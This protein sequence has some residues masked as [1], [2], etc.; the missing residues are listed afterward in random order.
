MPGQGMGGMPGMSQPQ[1][2]QAPPAPVA[3][4]GVQPSVV[5]PAQEKVTLLGVF[6]ILRPSWLFWLTNLLFF[7]PW[8]ICLGWHHGHSLGDSPEISCWLHGTVPSQWQSQ[9]KKFDLIWKI[10]G[11]WNQDWSAGC[12]ASQ[13]PSLGNRPRSAN[14]CWGLES[15][16]YWQR[17]SVLCLR[18]Q[19]S[20]KLDPNFLQASW[21]LRSFALQCTS[22]S[23]FKRESLSPLSCLSGSPLTFSVQCIVIT[24]P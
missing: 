7:N 4:A 10:T 21:I 8:N 12:C 2:S 3:V 18:I 1:Q 9:V 24:G 23:S 5:P 19:M 20:T 16:R 17:W 14:P 13:E 15:C 11:V 6:F 22:V